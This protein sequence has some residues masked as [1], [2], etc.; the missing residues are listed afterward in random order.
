MVC[1]PVS[2]ANSI[3][4]SPGEALASRIACL[5]DPGPLS[6]VVVTVNVIPGASEAAVTRLGKM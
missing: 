3:A 5:S 2:M 6:L 4:S 1:T